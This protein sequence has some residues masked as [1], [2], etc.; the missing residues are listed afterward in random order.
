M[1]ACV[2]TSSPYPMATAPSAIVQSISSRPSAVSTRQPL[3]RV[4]CV[5]KSPTRS[6]KSASG[7][8]LPVDA[9]P[10][11]IAAARDRHTFSL[12]RSKSR[13]AMATTRTRALRRASRSRS[14]ALERAGDFDGHRTEQ[15]D[16]ARVGLRAKG[17]GANSSKN[18]LFV[19]RLEEFDR[20]ERS[21][22]IGEE[23]LELLARRRWRVLARCTPRARVLRCGKTKLVHRDECSL[24]EI[25]RRVPRRWNRHDNVSPV[26]GGVVEPA[27]LAA[28]EQRNVSIDRAGH[29]HL[30]S[31]SRICD[32]TLRGAL[33]GSV[34]CDTHAPFERLLDRITVANRGYEVL[35]IVC[36]KA[37]SRSIV[38]RRPNERQ[39]LKAH[40]LH[41]T[42]DRRDVDRILRLVQDDAD[43]S[44]RISHDRSQSAET[45]R[46][47]D[48]RPGDR[49]TRR[50]RSERA[51]PAGAR[52]RRSFR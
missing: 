47:T 41:R 14:H 32:P 31:A 45:V 11:M 39:R 22:G 18:E 10:G 1:T 5:G 15:L 6:P 35:A 36:D 28:E 33:P 51:A 37:D 25:E 13:R 4:K 3:A 43:A 52:D 24:R 29:E 23:P 46:A 20:N 30:R 9:P 38:L 34:R 50:L 21:L 27:I 8:L 12:E 7:R 48:G 26:E 49:P 16:L 17:E 19:S 2:I 42:H 40:V 44:E